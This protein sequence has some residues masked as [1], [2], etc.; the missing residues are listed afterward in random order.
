MDSFETECGRLID[1]LVRQLVALANELAQAELVRARAARRDV[2]PAAL[3]VSARLQRA[4]ERAE[5]G[6]R[7]AAERRAALALRPA[8]RRAVVPSGKASSRGSLK[9]AASAH[10][11]PPLFVHKRSR[12]GSIQ[13][14]ERAAGESAPP[15]A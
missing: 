8:S 11:P 4:L 2:K 5:E 10:P 7:L 12:D 13:K 9:P 3:R 6:R 14:L 1:G 15:L